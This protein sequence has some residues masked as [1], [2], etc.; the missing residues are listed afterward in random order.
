M[1]VVESPLDVVRLASIGIKGG[2]AV[3]GA[4]VSQAQFA[5]I[6]GADRIIFAMDNDAVG[7]NSSLDLLN[8]C[9]Q[10]DKEA[11]YFDYSSTDAKDIG[12]MSLDEVRYGLDNA[13]H[14]VR[15]V[16]ATK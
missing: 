7:K 8:M 6:R 13:K 9:K 3:Y 14:T 2:V 4:L 5:L 12:G 16:K 1:I 10:V 11:W 15:G